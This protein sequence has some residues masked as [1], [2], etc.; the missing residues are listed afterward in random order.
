MMTW[1]C[2][3]G[4]KLNSLLGKMH[5]SIQMIQFSIHLQHLW[6]HC[7]KYN[8]KVNEYI[9]KKKKKTVTN[10]SATSDTENS[11]FSSWIWLYV[12]QPDL[13]P[14][15]KRFKF[16]LK[17][18]PQQQ[19]LDELVSRHATTAVKSHWI[20]CIRIHWNYLKCSWAYICF[21]WRPQRIT[22][23]KSSFM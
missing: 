15:A 7:K 3:L 2:Q 17:R 1:R 19:L 12:P 8:Q 10:Y 11:Y 6:L 22:K 9:Y 4:N 14:R 20:S 13:K 21:W 5:K 18:V 23:A 16:N